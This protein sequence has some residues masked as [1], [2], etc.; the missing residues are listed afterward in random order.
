M[1]AIKSKRMKSYGDI[2]SDVH[3][4]T[5]RGLVAGMRLLGVVKEIHDIELLIS[6]PNNLTGCVP[7][8]DISSTLSQKAE[9]VNMEVDGE[10]SEDEVRVLFSINIDLS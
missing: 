3:T 6:L 1:P 7:I 2:P 8:T 5:F 10:D 4:L 9:Q